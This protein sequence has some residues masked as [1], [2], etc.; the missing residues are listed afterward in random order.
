[1]RVLMYGWEF[2][3]HNSGGLG[4]ACYGLAKGLVQEG[5]DLSFVLP[6]KYPVSQTGAHMLFADESNPFDGEEAELFASG[7]INEERLKFLRGQYPELQYGPSLYDEVLRYAA[8][9]P[10]VALRSRPDVIHAHDW[11]CYPAGIAAKRATGAPLVVHVHATE[12]D[13]AGFNQTNPINDIER[14]GMHEADHILTVSE[15]T[16]NII[17]NYYDV[18]PNKVTVVYNGI[19]SDDKVVVSALEGDMKRLKD[20]GWGIVLFVGRLTMQKGPD[21][22][23]EAAK[24]VLSR[25]PQTL[26]VI[27]GSGDMERQIIDRAAFLGIGDKVIFTGFKR[28]KELGRLYQ[29][30]D[31]MVMPSV[32]EPFGLV[33]LEALL[34]G[35]PVIV[36]KQSGVAE[37]LRNA[38]KVDFWDIDEMAN[39]I[40]SVLEHPSLRE[41]LATEGGREV[42]AQAWSKVAQRCMMVYKKLVKSLL[43]V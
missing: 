25:R 21:Y 15:Y 16:K 42:R 17:V 29:V 26:F 5:V 39:K 22:F 34:N 36:S 23:L 30:A 18:D 24:K 33:P 40:A 20:A 8:L 7:Y 27:A 19:D 32:S 4:I 37:V 6:R 3:P 1:M 41:T 10:L 13:R 11:L 31:L 38:L 12:F 35:T 9:S 14:R 28:D 43:H 2:P